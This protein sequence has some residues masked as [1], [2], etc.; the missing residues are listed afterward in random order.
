MS[1]EETQIISDVDEK[2][3]NEKHSA[4]DLQQ[5]RH[6]NWDDNYELYRNKVKVNRLTQRQAVNIPLMKETIKTVLSK[7][8][9]APSIEWK[10]MGGDE[11]KEILLQEIWD[12][13]FRENKLELVDILDK[14][15]VLLY[16]LGVKKLNID[17]TG[18]PI[19]AMDIYDVVFDPLMLANDVETARFVIHQNIFRTLESIMHDDKYTQEGK[20]NLKLWL[21]TDAGMITSDENRLL[22]RERQQRWRDMGRSESTRS[23]TGVAHR[24]ISSTDEELFA[25]GDVIVNLTEHYTNL[26]NEETQE[27]ERHV[28]VYANDDVML[29][30]MTLKEAIGVE[31]WPFVVWSEDP[32][33]ND[34]YPDGVADLVRTPNKVMN[35]WFSQLVENRTLKNFQMH[36]FTPSQNYT[37]Q[38]YTPGPGAMLPAPPGED[39]NK[40][41]KPVEVSG[42]DDTMPA[43]AALTNIVERG[44][45]ATAIDKG[46]SEQGSQTLGEVEIIVGK[47]VERA[48]GIAKFYQMSWQEVAWKWE[49]LMDANAP[50]VLNLYK[51]GKSGRLYTKKVMAS[52]W[53]SDAGYR[54]LVSSSSEQ[55]Q[56]AI[57]TLQKFQAISAQYPNNTEL[58]S[59]T[60]K[61]SLQLLDITP[62]EQKRIEEAQQPAQPQVTN[63]AEEP[64]G[65]APPQPAVNPEEAELDA[66]I[67]Q[68]LANIGA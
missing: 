9:D 53:Q 33:T 36:W 57:A 11:D 59:L 20:D 4:N 61:R 64:A 32:E 10:E 40:V 8:D 6:A 30:D 50:K 56:N 31:F 5:R 24:A 25:A 42:L 7:I 22:W 38:T 3:K 66:E 34:V 55:E 1:P 49:Q 19:D 51:Q 63:S 54:P 16:G 21:G 60:L 17:E 67:Q 44:T 28:M 27:W 52:D 47:S 48:V 62:E 12:A 29:S 18:V 13:N 15:N 26:W 2:L 65:E 37:P 23:H 14:K 35:V 68:S 39:I 45:G 46:Q 41:I 58:Q 43:I